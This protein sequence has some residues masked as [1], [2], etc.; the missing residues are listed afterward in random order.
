MAS[1][2]DTAE[3]AAP[4]TSVFFK[5]FEDFV[6]FETVFEGF[7]QLFNQLNL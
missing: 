2:I 7:L 3:F 4:Q 1:A 5:T 6:T